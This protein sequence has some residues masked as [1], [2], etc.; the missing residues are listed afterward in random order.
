MSSSGEILFLGDPHGHFDRALEVIVHRRPA[1][2]VILGDMDL[3]RPLEQEVE[4][5]LRHG[6]EVWWIHGNHDCDRVEWHDRLFNSALGDRNLHGRV[7]EIAGIR[8][9]GLGGVFREKIWWPGS[10]IKPELQMRFRSRQDWLRVNPHLKWRDGLPLKH[11]ASIWWEDYERLWD[12]RAD[13]LVTHEAPSAHEYGFQVFDDLAAAMKV[14]TIV[15]GHQHID[16]SAELPAGVR[17]IGVGLAAVAS[18]NG[19]V[20]LAS[21]V[22]RGRHA[23]AGLTMG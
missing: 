10:G 11:R 1:A 7:V 8:I 9:A 4:L 23:A 13:V 21:L 6:I 17:V 14:R 3:E 20:V 22:N 5:L 16:Y 15:H 2:V 19:E 12:E 18:L